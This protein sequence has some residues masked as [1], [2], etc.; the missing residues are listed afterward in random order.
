M[1]LALTLLYMG[2]EEGSNEARG[3]EEVFTI[4]SHEVEERT[5]SK[6]E[7][8]EI[9]KLN[10][11]NFMVC[12]TRKTIS[13][14]NMRRDILFVVTISLKRK[15]VT[16]FITHFKDYAQT[17][18]NKVCSK[19][20]QREAAPVEKWLE[21]RELVRRRFVSKHYLR[22]CAQRLQAL[23]QGSKS[24]DDSFKE[25]EML[26][27]RLEIDKE[28]ENTLARF[29]HCLNIYVTKRVELQVYEDMEE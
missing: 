28:E 2:L 1:N 25:M 19:R 27:E 29:L 18:W 20:R 22:D 4:E 8:L 14:G 17:W 7:V 15:N 13:N 21:L 12:L 6:V 9:L 10:S 24:G 23:S 5:I 11:Q 26:M 3:E 16:I